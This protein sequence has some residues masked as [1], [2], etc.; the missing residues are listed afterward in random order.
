MIKIILVAVNAKY[1]HSNLAIYSLKKYA[2]QYI[3]RE[4][5]EIELAEYTINQHIPEIIQD[6]YKK[7]PDVLAFSCY[8][9]N[10]EYV[11]R[12]IQDFRKIMPDLPIW[13][14]G[15]E[16]YYDA[17]G[18]MNQ[19]T[20]TTGVMIGEGEAIF[21]NLALFYQEGNSY[22]NVEEVPVRGLIYRNA[23]GTLVQTEREPLLNLSEIPFPYDEVGERSRLDSVA[24]SNV[25]SQLKNRILYYESSRGCPFSC[26]YCLSSVEKQLRFRDLELVKKEL[27]IFLE[28]KVPQVKFVDRTFNCNKRHAM[29]I[30][31]FILE[32]HNGVTNFHFE[33]AADLI[34]EEELELLQQMPEGIIQFEIG[35]QSTNLDT[36]EE[37]ERSMSL[38]KVKRVVER[39]QAFGTIHLHLDLI[40]GLPF[41][42]FG[43]FQQSF[44]DV[45]AMKP[46]QLQL[47]FLK[48]LKGTRMAHRASE[49][50][51]EYSAYPP[52][53]VISTN[54]IA[55]DE[56]LELKRVENVL[57]I[58][59]NS[60]QFVNVIA[61]IERYFAHPFQ[62]YAEL[63]EFYETQF[64]V[65]EKHSRMAR[66]DLL[67]AGI[68]AYLERTGR[69]IGADLERELE[70]CL[71]L[72][73]Y[74]VYLRENM[75]NR[76]E[77]FPK[78]DTSRYRVLYR[79]YKKEGRQAHIE[80]FHYD[81]QGY[82]EGVRTHLQTL[83][84]ADIQEV[85]QDI[86]FDYGERRVIGY[87]ARTERIQIKDEETDKT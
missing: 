67:L 31:R 84:N 3:A 22:G 58:Y 18:F 14:G 82:A 48:V 79:Q 50:G 72:M 24:P 63:G 56:L 2:D 35:V 6:L 30:W 27:S 10:R 42:N 46:E 64:Q 19:Y 25:I 13:A 1:I 47:G 80:H 39:I 28:H 49:Y 44:N 76:P 59:Y 75:K 66:Y 38:D 71:E 62:M 36:I 21:K 68:R 7:A 78:L 52:Y 37:I 4:K 81:I 45:Y 8:I 23:D 87:A 12:I 70:I 20:G 57:E 77:Y 54:W 26:S 53:E 85:E 34:G 15:P 33:I 60:G 40:A 69:Y 73:V 32:N 5:V 9:W 17:E 86:V 61:Y 11:G 43:R 41:E 74:D 65:G 16:A 83:Q 51:L 55:Y 29:E